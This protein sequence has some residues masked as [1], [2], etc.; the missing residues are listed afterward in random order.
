MATQPLQLLGLAR[1][2]LVSIFNFVPYKERFGTCR[3]ICTHLRTLLTPNLGWGCVDPNTFKLLD[4]SIFIQ[5]VSPYSDNLK[6]Y[7]LGM[8]RFKLQVFPETPAN[9]R[10]LRTAKLIASQHLLE[11]HMMTDGRETAFNL[12]LRLKSRET[13]IVESKPFHD[14]LKWGTESLQ[15]AIDI[16]AEHPAPAEIFKSIFIDPKKVTGTK[17]CFTAIRAILI[18]DY[19]KLLKIC[20][21][22]VQRVFA[23]LVREKKMRH[24]FPLE[25]FECSFPD[26]II[27]GLC[28]GLNESYNLGGLVGIQVNNHQ[29]QQLCASIKGKKLESFRVNIIEKITE[30]S[31]CDLERTLASVTATHIEIRY[32][33]H[34][35]GQESCPAEISRRFT[36]LFQIH[37][38][39]E[40][41][42]S[43]IFD[44]CLNVP[45][46][47]NSGETQ[48]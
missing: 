48:N 18:D 16:Y 20:P 29:F 14:L 3:L 6:L 46:N 33:F 5:H 28:L 17:A 47:P 41:I 22:Q 34:E 19:L 42:E 44:T 12:Y 8:S 31:F 13:R 38:E 37:K 7:P 2:C 26:H 39:N 36:I 1:D 45:K 32:H 27:S 4:Y 11:L 23:Y 25:S 21:E 30:K 43:L 24:L 40:K 35:I 15:H 9:M 10:M